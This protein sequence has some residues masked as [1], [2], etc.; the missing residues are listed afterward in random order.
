MATEAAK[1]RIILLSLSLLGFFDEMYDAL[2]R[3]LGSKAHVQ[4]VKKATSAMRLL[5]EQPPPSAILVTDEGL[6]LP[7]NAHVWDAVVR[8]VREGGPA[9]VTGHFSGQ[10]LPP[11]MKPFFAAVGRD[12]AARLAPRYS[13][14]ALFVR[15]VT[16][17][18]SWYVSN[19]ESVV[20]S[21]VFP[22]TSVNT[23]QETAVAFARVGD[24]KLGY[25]GDVNAEKDS[26]AVILA[27]CGLLG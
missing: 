23:P 1:P 9:V 22:P 19:E 20:E 13:Q 21:M 17:E 11:D 12:V 24:G 15:N 18:Q 27:M 7:E 4:R 26:D 10:V 25:L 16:P 2:L 3:E 14:K 8:Y 5:S 6:T